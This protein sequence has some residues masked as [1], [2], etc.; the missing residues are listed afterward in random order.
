MNPGKLSAEDKKLIRQIQGDLSISQT[1]YAAL[2]HQVGLEEKEFL[3]R[4]RRLVR[5]GLIRRFGAI[6]RHQKAGYRGNAMVVWKITE[7]QIPRV[8][9][10]L[11]SFAA[12]SHGYLRPPQPRWPFNL[13]TMV[14]GRSEKDCRLATRK[15]SKETGLKEY[16]LLFSKREHKKSSMRYFEHR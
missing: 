1:P 10:A 6:L 12:V 5:L 13:Y 4:I 14:H 11:A 8:S 9:Q 15:I 16:R 2:A 7:E 3:K